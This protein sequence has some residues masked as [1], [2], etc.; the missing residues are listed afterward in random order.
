MD[1]SFFIQWVSE[2]GLELVPVLANDCHSF[3]EAEYWAINYDLPRW[4]T[5]DTQFIVWRGRPGDKHT[6]HAHFTV[7]GTMRG[8]SM[9]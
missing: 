1:K 4:A 6:P 5:D 2:D 3:E 9:E 8:E 7:K